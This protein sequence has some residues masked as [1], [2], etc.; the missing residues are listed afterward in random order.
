MGVILIAIFVFTGLYFA[1]QWAFPHHDHLVVTSA[2]KVIMHSHLRF[3]CRVAEK[4]GLQE[5]VGPVCGPDNRA[6]I[7]LIT[8]KGLPE[9]VRLN[10]NEQRYTANCQI[11]NTLDSVGCPSSA[12]TSFNGFAIPPNTCILQ[13]RDRRA[14]RI[15]IS[16]YK[17]GLI[18]NNTPHD[19]FL[20][21]L[22]I[23]IRKSWY[24]PDDAPYN[25]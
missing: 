13:V 7:L 8:I 21:R 14:I 5:R 22:V 18:G 16:I 24:V 1:Y 23:P 10:Y 25:G 4:G 15:I 2:D 12:G 9:G 3:K 11:S 20:R 6:G 17:G 19:Y